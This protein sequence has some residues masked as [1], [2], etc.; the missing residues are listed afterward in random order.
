MKINHNFLLIAPRYIQWLG[1]YYEFPIGLAYI[2]S[3]L[4]TEGYQ[5]TC[6]NLNHYDGTVESLIEKSIKE[7]Q[8]DIVCT[9]G[10][11]I[12][13]NKI[14]LI[15]NVVKAIDPNIM[16]ILGGGI[17]SSDPHTIMNALKPDFGVIGEGEVTI[18]ELASCLDR[19][20]YYETIE[21]LVYF[22]QNGSLI[23]NPARKPIKNLGTIPYPDYQGFEIET[24][25]ARQ[26]PND[27]YHMYP[28]DNPRV[29]PVT[30]SRSCPYKCT[31]CYHP[32]GNVYRQRPLDDLFDEIEL[33]KSRYQVNILSI[34]DELFSINDERIEEFCAR[35][36][37][38]NLRYLVQM[39]VD[40]VN[41]STL[42]MLKN[43][44]CIAIS[45]GLESASNTILKS[46]KK[47]TTLSMIEKTL[48]LT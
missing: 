38:L 34:V 25:L 26:M 18:R 39:R 14:K 8:I 23:K 21:G 33:L 2:S 36:K 7:H 32:L 45:Y 42:K 40:S 17:I 22:N 9:G 47:F 28:F 35:I 46:M 13:F 41:T 3:A 15:L 4:K 5:V 29:I 12:H 20:A 24:Y 43:S 6:L 10:L 1:Q 11:S 48:A 37:S 31:F 27:E 30:A 19:P 44:G 16:S